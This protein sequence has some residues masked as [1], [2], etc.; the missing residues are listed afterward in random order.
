MALRRV[1]ET[2]E[3]KVDP[4][5]GIYV[6]MEGIMEVRYCEYDD[7][8][9][10]D[11]F[12]FQRVNSHI[13]DDFCHKDREEQRQNIFFCLVCNCDLKS[14]IPLRDH[15][16]GA[17][18]IRK[19]LE[20]KRQ[21]LGL[22]A[23]PQNKPKVKKQKPPKGRVN[24]SLTL[25]A[26]L[27]D[28]DDPVLGLNAITEYRNGDGRRDPPW[29][30]C[31]Q[32]GCKSAWGNSDDMLNHVKNHKH[33]RNFL[34]LIY[35]EDPRI[36]SLNKN[37]LIE[38]ALTYATDHNCLL[39]EDRDYDSIQSQKD[40]ALYKKLSTRPQDWSEDKER[41]GVTN[42]NCIPIGPR[43]RAASPP[44]FDEAS[45]RST[46]FLTDTQLV[47]ESIADHQEGVGSVRQQVAR[48]KGST[49]DQ[50]YMACQDS[51]SFYRELF[52]IELQE[53]PRNGTQADRDLLLADQA[54]L[55]DLRELE[56]ELTHKGE[57]E[58]MEVKQINN[59]LA[60]LEQEM[61]LYSSEPG[62][63]AYT[64]YKER[65]SVLSDEL[66]TFN[67]EQEGYRAKKVEFK[68]RMSVLWRSFEAR[69]ESDVV[70][71]SVHTPPA[72]G[73]EP[74]P[75]KTSAQRRQE[76]RVLYTGLFKAAVVELVAG[77]VKARVRG[78]SDDQMKNITIKIVQEKIMNAE[79]EAHKELS[80]DT[81]R[82]TD[83]VRGR[84]RNWLEIY[85]KAKY[86]QTS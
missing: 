32:E 3:M 24:V 20:K 53:I 36:D 50:E 47:Q 1:G 82:F 8:E 27:R 60:Q 23:D 42:T 37:E 30:T 57:R 66:N 85:L 19:A 11:F 64:T 39:A 71:E 86:G 29:Y 58:V 6:E 80:W 65:L 31:S 16:M 56:K 79:I 74:R 48:F 62:Q 2:E 81:F 43:K 10:E 46:P 49:G 45:W 26:R 69:S 83:S 54:L 4:A 35:P 38:K 17:K 76:D 21:V 18:H 28:M 9:A 14:I 78:Y 67:P 13:P 70:V 51:I 72:T 63:R 12:D 59:S 40:P 25:E 33:Q 75:R 5:K 84:I 44:L 22:L 68:T 77:E 61:E 41:L 34:K 55:K 7:Y 73:S 52:E 15:V